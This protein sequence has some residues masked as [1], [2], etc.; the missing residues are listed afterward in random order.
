MFTQLDPPPAPPGTAARGARSR[1]GRGAPTATGTTSTRSQSWRSGGAESSSIS[2]GHA[3]KR[4]RSRGFAPPSS[5][6]KRRRR[7]GALPPTPTSDTDELSSPAELPPHLSLSSVRHSVSAHSTSSSSSSTSPPS[8]AGAVGAG[9]GAAACDGGR[10]DK[11]SPWSITRHMQRMAL[12]EPIDEA[13]ASPS[14]RGAGTEAAHSAALVPPRRMCTGSAATPQLDVPLGASH[15]VVR[16]RY[17]DVN[18]EL[19]ELAISRRSRSEGRLS[20]GRCSSVSSGS[21]NIR[22]ISSGGGSGSGGGRSNTTTA[23]A[24]SCSAA[25]SSLLSPPRINRAPFR[26]AT[27]SGGGTPAA[28]ALRRARMAH[29]ASLRMASSGGEV[30]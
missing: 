4:P 5:A 20:G 28:A 21:S 6:A 11:Q 19:R 22:I 30:F 1:R 18:S 27:P 15:R 8:S 24:T 9:T 13:P 10:G 17:F 7:A 2:P 26:I 12:M 16:N 23:A 14:D 3:A 29:F 25:S